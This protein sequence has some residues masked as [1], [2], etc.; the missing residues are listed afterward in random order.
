MSAVM[1][2]ACAFIGKQCKSYS[3]HKEEFFQ[4]ILRKKNK[5]GERKEDET[6]TA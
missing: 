1:L 6:N 3:V 2:F 4:K 5:Q